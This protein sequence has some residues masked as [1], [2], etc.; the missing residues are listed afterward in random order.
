MNLWCKAEYSA[1]LLHPSVSH[2]P[3]ET[4]WYADLLLKKHFLVLTML[5]TIVLPNICEGFFE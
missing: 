1:S 3:S 5:K 4:F 2:D